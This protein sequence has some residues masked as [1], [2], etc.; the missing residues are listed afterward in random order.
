MKRKNPFLVSGLTAGMCAFGVFCI[1]HFCPTPSFD[2]IILITDHWLLAFSALSLSLLLGALWTRDVFQSIM[3]VLG[4]FFLLSGFYFMGNSMLDWHSP[5][6][7]KYYVIAKGKNYEKSGTNPG[8]W[9]YF[10]KGQTSQ[11]Q[12]FRFSTSV[13]HITYQEWEIAQPERW[14]Y[15]E[16]QER[17]GAFAQPGGKSRD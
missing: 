7:K 5:E 8:Y 16:V 17:S 6:V 3:L 11:G 1:V 15:I 10:L 9:N 4:G 13:G 12:K 2:P 14:V